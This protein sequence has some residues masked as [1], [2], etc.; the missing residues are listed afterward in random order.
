MKLN[1]KARQSTNLYSFVQPCFRLDSW[2]V[3]YTVGSITAPDC[4]TESTSA[5]DL[6]LDW[7][8]QRIVL[9]TY[10]STR[11]FISA[12]VYLL[13][14]VT[15]WHFPHNLSGRKV[16]CI[17]Q[18]EDELEPKEHSINLIGWSIELHSL[19]PSCSNN[20]LECLKKSWGSQW[21]LPTTLW[22]IC[23]F[24]CWMSS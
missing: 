15:Q 16:V 7:P 8:V 10:R 14:T 11:L 3:Y 12:H 17:V 22:N 24:S 2:T 19:S 23:C 9:L 20:V 13:F 4:A 5:P 21:L 1:F 18:N 6:W